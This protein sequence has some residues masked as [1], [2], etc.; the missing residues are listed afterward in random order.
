MNIVKRHIQY[1]A[2]VTDCVIIPGWGGL[3]AC[4]RPA[5]VEGGVMFAPSRMMVFNPALTHDDG[6]LA[7][8]L[9]RR[10]GMSYEAARSEIAAEAAAMR[11]EYEATG[12]IVIPR[13][14]SFT[15]Q[16][17]GTMMFTAAD[18][19]IASA[20]YFALP[21]LPLAPATPFA[22]ES[23]DEKMHILRP[24][25]SIGRRVLRIAAFVAI[26]LGLAITL[27][28]PIT[29]NRDAEPEFAGIGGKIFSSSESR[30]TALTQDA[31]ADIN[32]RIKFTL[33]IPDS[34]L[35]VAPVP[36]SSG[37][38]QEDEARYFLI[39]SSHSSE[40][41]AKRWIGN[42]PGENYR[43]IHG[44]NRYRVYAAT[45]NSIEEAMSLK[46]NAEFARRNPDAWVYR[47]R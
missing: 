16:A 38:A 4:H 15:R 40:S 19:G 25:E 22:R 39:V 47:R 8:S 35:A 34:A 43:V 44:G 33:T 7:M 5:R 1:L 13:I 32:R 3:I 29:V 31:D 28:T 42:H 6:R 37:M 24:K 9:M 36:P 2:A 14:G 10:E 17:D 18:D 20:R 12:R 23:E 27:S 30:S 46:E 41:E 45:G 11:A 26:L 21:G